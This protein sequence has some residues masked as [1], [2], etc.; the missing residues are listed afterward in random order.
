[1]DCCICENEIQPT[2]SGWEHGHNAQPIRDGRCCC[3][4]NARLVVPQRLDDII[5]REIEELK[6]KDVK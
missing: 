2:E 5:E 1:M 3:K 4:C 6:S